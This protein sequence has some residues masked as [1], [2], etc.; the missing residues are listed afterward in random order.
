[1]FYNNKGLYKN[2]VTL[3]MQEELVKQSQ[4]SPKNKAFTSV[5]A[6]TTQVMS[7]G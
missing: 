3:V 7:E 2:C 4:N 1:M 6:T 5:Q